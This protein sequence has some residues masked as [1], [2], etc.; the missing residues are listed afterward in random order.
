MLGLT[1]QSYFDPFTMA[2][3]YLI[4]FFYLFVFLSVTTC[5]SLGQLP[6]L[7]LYSTLTLGSLKG[8]DSQFLSNI[9]TLPERKVHHLKHVKPKW[10]F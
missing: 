5:K 2:L 7:D 4:F 10:F 1:N 6:L 8:T 9:F 3:F